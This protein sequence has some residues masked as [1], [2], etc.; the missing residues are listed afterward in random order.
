MGLCHRESLMMTLAAIHVCL[1]HSITVLFEFLGDTLM[2]V[3]ESAQDI[4]IAKWQFAT[5]LLP[6][7][8]QQSSSI[9]DQPLSCHLLVVVSNIHILQGQWNVDGHLQVDQLAISIAIIHRVVVSVAP[10]S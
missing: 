6:C 1:L 8:S 10:D 5:Y 3:F 7:A 4:F 2:Q 9:L